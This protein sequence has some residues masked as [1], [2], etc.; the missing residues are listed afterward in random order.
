MPP[1][2]IFYSETGGKSAPFYRS[3]GGIKSAL[4]T[5]WRGRNHQWSNHPWPPKV[6]RGEI[7]WQELDVET[8]LPLLRG[9]V[10]Q[11]HI[12]A[13]HP[14]L[15]TGHDPIEDHDR[16]HSVGPQDHTHGDAL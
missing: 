14:N 11:A 16:S 7:F 5:S 9:W 3:L 8:G 6:Y 15:V 10:T 13:H 2:V 12:Q 4:K 1:D